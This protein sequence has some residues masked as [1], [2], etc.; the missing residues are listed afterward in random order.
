MHGD[1]LADDEP[2]PG[3]SSGSELPIGMQ[4][5][6]T[7]VP[8]SV[9]TP[10]RAKGEFEGSSQRA[11]RHFMLSFRALFMVMLV[12]VTMLI[13]SSNKNPGDYFWTTFGFAIASA[14][15]GLVV[16][17]ADAMTPDKRLASV[18]GVYIGVLLGL[19]AAVAFGALIDM[20]MSAWELKEV[21]TVLLYTNMAKVVI[22][23]II[24]YVTASVVLTTKDDF[25]LVIPYVQFA[26][27]R[28]GLRPMLLDSSALIDGRVRDLATSGFLDAP[29]IVPRFVLDELQ[30]LADS[31]DRTKRQRGKR[32]LDMVAELQVTAMSPSRRS[33]P[34]ARRSIACCSKWR[35]RRACACSPPTPISRRSA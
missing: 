21:A 16:I 12:T 20:V 30:K 24:C 23:I 33:R 17:V 5:A 1:S 3:E 15:A 25:R 10:G 34:R 19:I 28:R 4:Q 13:V 14:I 22:G 32:G 27:E 29:L 8:M 6:S 18:V 9:S 2:G 35:A 7:A 11:G 31:S 26:R